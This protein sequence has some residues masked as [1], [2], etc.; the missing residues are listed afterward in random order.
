MNIILLTS[1]PIAD[2]IIV[3][4]LLMIDQPVPGYSDTGQALLTDFRC[5][6]ESRVV[7]NP[8]APALNLVRK[9]AEGHTTKSSYLK[10][11]RDV[12]LDVAVS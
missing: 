12:V 10:S 7:S 5:S 8:N 9:L 3:C 2:K 4:T 11:H 6:R 1:V